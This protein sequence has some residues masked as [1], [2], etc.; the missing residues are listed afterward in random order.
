MVGDR[1]SCHKKINNY[2][3]GTEMPPPANPHPVLFNGGLFSCKFNACVPPATE[4]EREP[5]RD[6]LPQSLAHRTGR[7]HESDQDHKRRAWILQ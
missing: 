5:R 6:L 7:R 4:T 2:L 3:M 1:L